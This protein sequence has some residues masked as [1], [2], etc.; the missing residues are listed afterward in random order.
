MQDKGETIGQSGSEI[1][2]SK[3]NLGLASK[4]PVGEGLLEQEGSA[5]GVKASSSLE[6]Y[7]GGERINGFPLNGDAKNDGDLTRLTSRSKRK[8]IDDDDESDDSR[9][10][11]SLGKPK[12]SS[13]SVVNSES[14]TVD[15]ANDVRSARI[16]R[17]HASTSTKKRPSVHDESDEDEAEFDAPTVRRVSTKSP[18][19]EDNN[20]AIPKKKVPRKAESDFSASNKSSLLAQME[21]PPSTTNAPSNPA[22]KP[23][24]SGPMTTN[25]NIKKLPTATAARSPTRPESSRNTDIN[26]PRP[27]NPT[28]GPEA[29]LEPTYAV[30]STNVKWNEE[31]VLKDL[32]DLCDRLSQDSSFQLVQSGKIDLNGSFLPKD[33]ERYDFFDTNEKGEIIFQSRIP[34]FPED[35][36]KGMQEHDLAWWGILDPA[37]G[38]GLRAAPELKSNLPNAENDRK[39]NGQA[40]SRS[41][42]P[43]RPPPA[44][45]GYRGRESRGPPHPGWARP[46]PNAGE[47]WNEDHRGRGPTPVDRRGP[48]RGRR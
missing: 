16:S 8:I 3:Y 43:I 37:V 42:P 22:T 35:F 19:P 5:T 20:A 27:H 34:M 39:K 2:V 15:Q 14:N 25:V 28:K 4:A 31:L 41:Q 29:S 33:Q 24:S 30:A 1:N 13:T 48:N 36:T 9:T 12:S 10:A 23:A 17:L 46:P 21:Q 44:N 45:D 11:T 38:D 26:G 18:V 7:D 32:Q 6:L 40:D 47:N